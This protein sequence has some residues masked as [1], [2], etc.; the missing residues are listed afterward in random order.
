[1]KMPCVKIGGGG[2]GLR[3]FTLVEL[4]VVIA[5]IG[6]LIALLL[7]AVQ[8]AREAARRMQCTNNIKQISLALMTYHD[9]YKSFPC[10]IL[11]A[12]AP[13]NDRASA[14]SWHIS[15]FPFIE[16]TAQYD[17]YTQWAYYW[18]GN[19]PETNFAVLSP[20]YSA[21]TC[22]SDTKNL[23][24]NWP[25]NGAYAKHNY[26]GCN[27]NTGIY[28]ANGVMTGWVREIAEGSSFV[29]HFGALFRPSPFPS[30]TS[31][32]DGVSDALFNT[33]GSVSD[34]TS[35]TVGI[36]EGIQDPDGDNG[37]RGLIWFCSAST[38]SAFR[39]PNTNEPDNVFNNMTGDSTR[40]PGT[41]EL[42]VGTSQTAVILSAR[43][44]H[45]GGV[46]AGLIDG[47]VQFISST[48]N[49]QVW[50]AYSTLRG[51][52]SLSAF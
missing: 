32:G 37:I 42:D 31:E 38:F 18:W 41:D 50:R 6:I 36:S 45:T 40:H 24:Y 39:Q 25:G 8:A 14:G 29:R 26:L 7:P 16:M 4:L 10:G 43:S 28:H 9:A 1:M 21:F 47:S 12:V 30:R 23:T 15:L 19:G 17:K 5:I 48:I 33:I 3:A 46:N 2:G 20:R 22:P 49:I 44:N 13:E 34:G 35:N 11:C 27:G 51:G 52:E